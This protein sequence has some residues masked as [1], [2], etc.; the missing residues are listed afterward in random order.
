MLATTFRDA[1]LDPRVPLHWLLVLSH[2]GGELGRF[3]D[4]SLEIDGRH[5]LPALTVT[6]GPTLTADP[7]NGTTSN[8]SAR[9]T[10]SPVP[11]DHYDLA[12]VT[13][14]DLGELYDAPLNGANALLL[15]WAEGTPL[16]EARVKLDG[17]LDPPKLLENG[18]LQLEIVSRWTRFDTRLP[19]YRVDRTYNPNAH[20]DDSGAGFA[21]LCGDF[22][23]VPCPVYDNTGNDKAAL[24]EG[25]VAPT[26]IYRNDTIETG[27]G[28]G[29][30]S[31]SRGFPITYVYDDTALAQDDITATGSGYLDDGTEAM[32]DGITEAS[33]Y[34]TGTAAALISH[35]ADQLHYVGRRFCGWSADRIDRTA[36]AALRQATP[37]AVGAMQALSDASTTFSAI[38][39]DAMRILRAAV[40]E[41]N[42]KLTARRLDFDRQ[43]TIHL[44]DGVNL[45][46]VESVSWA[47]VEDKP[48]KLKIRYDYGWRKK[49]K[50]L[51]YRKSLELNA[52]NFAP[53]AANYVANENQ[54]VELPEIQTKQH[55][56]PATIENA[57]VDLGELYDGDRKIVLAKASREAHLLS[58]YDTLL[59]TTRHYPSFDGTGCAS[60]PFLVLGFT[61]VDRD[62]LTVQLLEC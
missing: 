24:A 53:F 13:P 33:G 39:Q 7:F 58:V 21:I 30:E 26:A 11:L 45:S 59:L 4:A 10:L 51:D 6:A 14:R 25:T 28:H 44:Q 48:T 60:K 3:A 35:P 36:L 2:P 32:G 54:D 18:G 47:A 1:A 41:E 40:F 55:A 56:D 5:Y 42:G 23:R 22:R 50:T 17:Y 34:F 8:S 43:P 57:L 15:L 16:S 20:E 62:N 19:R 61:K 29:H 31:D 49:R 27:D 9:V 38:A 52:A 37:W 12:R 46:G